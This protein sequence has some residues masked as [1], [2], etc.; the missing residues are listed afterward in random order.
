MSGA[1]ARAAARSAGGVKSSSS[2]IRTSAPL[3]AAPCSTASLAPSRN[4]QERQ[5]CTGRIWAIN[6]PIK[7]QS[8]KRHVEAFRD[9]G[10]EAGCDGD[11]AAHL[12]R[13]VV[14]GPHRKAARAEERIGVRRL[15]F[16][17]V[18]RI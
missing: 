14:A 1:S 10:A 18:E 13:V 12:A 16:R 15:G 17:G 5:S 4:S 7:S 6:E 3:A 11:A 8:L 9:V 2:W